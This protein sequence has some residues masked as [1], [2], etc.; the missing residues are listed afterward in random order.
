MSPASWLLWIVALAILSLLL[1]IE[2]W[3]AAGKPSIETAQRRHAT[4][5]IVGL[6]LVF[7]I[8]VVA[9]I[10]LRIHQT[11]GRGTQA[12]PWGTVGLLYLAM[13]MGMVTQYFFF[14][15]HR[16]FRWREFII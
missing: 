14:Y 8:S 13:I 1:I 9:A 7:G 12:V 4:R 10:L 16:K 3:H 15:S 2:W 11:M 6:L 5:C